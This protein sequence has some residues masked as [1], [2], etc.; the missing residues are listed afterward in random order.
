MKQINEL[1][2]VYIYIERYIYY[3]CR[4]R[5]M[6][7]YRCMYSCICAYLHLCLYLYLY[8]CIYVY[9]HVQHEDRRTEGPTYDELS[10]LYAVRPPS[11]KASGHGQHRGATASGRGLAKL[12]GPF[13]FRIVGPHEYSQ[14]YGCYG[15]IEGGHRI[16]YT[17]TVSL[18]SWLTKRTLTVAHMSHGQHSS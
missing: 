16:L 3:T 10:K 7:T 11:P 12:A 18:S 8:V 5:H 4:Y 13:V 14:C 17:D 6:H 1:V 9:T 2:C 15:H